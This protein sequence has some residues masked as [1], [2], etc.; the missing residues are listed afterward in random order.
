MV[1]SLAVRGLVW[2]GEGCWLHENSG[3][4]HAGV[5]C[6]VPRND[7]SAVAMTVLVSLRGRRPKQSMRLL[8]RTQPQIAVD[9]LISARK[10]A[11]LPVLL[12][13]CGTCVYLIFCRIFCEIICEI[14]NGV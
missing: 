1:G 11:R 4:C 3:M 10:F 8:K 6:F 12:S 7:E 5:D 14:K 9:L 13:A 2:V